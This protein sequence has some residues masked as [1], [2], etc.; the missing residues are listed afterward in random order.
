M[1][2]AVW[3]RAALIQVRSPQL[4]RPEST[5]GYLPFSIAGAASGRS[6]AV[7]AHCGGASYR[8]GVCSVT[9]LQLWVADITPYCQRRAL[10]PDLAVVVELGVRSRRGCYIAFDV[11]YHFTNTL[12]LISTPLAGP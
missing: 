5:S 7:G 3:L 11:T 4:H 10:L 2:A 12:G 6:T 8:I 9:D 1:R